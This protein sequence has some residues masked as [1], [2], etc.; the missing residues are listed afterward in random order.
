MKI[1]V[2]HVQEDV[3]SKNERD[4]QA[5]Q[6]I[7]KARLYGKVESGESYLAAEKARS[8]EVIDGLTR[9]LEAIKEHKITQA[10]L[11]V[12]RVLRQK[13]ANEGKIYEDEIVALKGQLEK[14][15]E[16]G[17]NRAK[18]IRQILG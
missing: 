4:P 16:E 8:Q 14:V 18:A 17:E 7:E 9:Q 13:A 12:L 10:E 11:E 2:I 1:I 3:C 5:T 6:L 15:V